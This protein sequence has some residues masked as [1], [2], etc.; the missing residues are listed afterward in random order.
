MVLGKILQFVAVFN[1]IHAARGSDMVWG[2]ATAAYQVEGYRGADGRQPSIWD[3]FDTDGVSDDFPAMTPSG[4]PH[5]FAGQSGQF[6]YGDYT[7]YNESVSILTDGGFGMVRMSTSWSRLMTYTLD[8]STGYLSWKRN[9]AGIQHYKNVMQAYKRQG[10]QI[11]LTMFH[12]DLPLLLEKKARLNNSSFWLCHDWAT[13]VF[14]EY[15]QLLLSEYGSYVTWWNTINEPFTLIGNGYTSGVHA[16]GRCSDRKD[17]FDGDSGKEPYIAAKGLLL[18]HAAA[19][20]NWERAGRPGRG[21]GMTL[22]CDWRIPFTDSQDDKNAAERSLEWSAGIFAD[23][24]HRGEWPAS[25][26]EHLGSRL[27]VWTES[28]K[29][30][31]HGSHD[32]YFFMNT[33]TTN[34]ARAMPNYPCGFFCDP[35]AQLSGYNF[36]S[37][38]P[39]GTPSTNGWLFNYGPGMGEMAAWYNRRYPGLKYVITET[40]WS[41]ATSSREEAML[42]TERCNFYRDYIGNLSAIAVREKYEVVAFTAWSIMDN[43]EWADGY[44]SRFGL[45]YVDYQTMERSPKLSYKWFQKYI[46]RLKQLPTD[47]KPLPPCDPADFVSQNLH[48][49]VIV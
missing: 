23:P 22:N 25:M 45:V 19:F 7:R 10:I 36:T 41:S 29:H 28:E 49:P 15:A 40:G 1:S 9:E 12:W 3:A 38:K 21:C 17:C 13:A 47:G 33:Y 14:G 39:I 18:G 11:A 35:M 4:N 34:Y 43:Y 8:E 6:A 31:V 37:N 20:R 30:L 16:P 24:M 2:T 32:A 48:V 46:T 44:S 42:D 27:P 26:V 5:V